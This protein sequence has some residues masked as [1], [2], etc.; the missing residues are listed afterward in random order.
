M[1][2]GLRQLHRPDRRSRSHP[3]P[4]RR[5]CEELATEQETAVIAVLDGTVVYEIDSDQLTLT[6]GDHGLIYRAG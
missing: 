3:L 2:H 1:Q 5:A 4:S 6:K